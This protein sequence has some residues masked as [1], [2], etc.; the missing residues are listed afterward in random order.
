[1]LMISGSI[2]QSVKMATMNALIEEKKNKGFVEKQ[3][4]LSPEERMLEQFKEQ[5]AQEKEAEY[6]NGI[7]NKVMSGKTLSSEEIEYLQQKNPELLKKYR[8]MQEEKKSYERQLRRCKTKEEVERVRVNKINGYLAQAKSISHNA[9]IP[10]GEK[11]AMLEE[12]MA[13]LTNIEKVHAKFVKSEQY[14]KMPRE[15]EIAKE[16][17]ELSSE[18]SE[19]VTELLKEAGEEQEEIAKEIVEAGETA[20]ESPEADR[21]QDS[22]SPEAGRTQDSKSPEAGEI[23]ETLQAGTKQPEE[24]QALN[25]T[26]VQGTTS[27][28]EPAGAEG[29]DLA[30]KAVTLIQSALSNLNIYSYNSSGNTVSLE[31]DQDTGKRIDVKK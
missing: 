27:A 17:A 13:R 29:D 21:T 4:Q 7:A 6:T 26:H 19:A 24:V 5:A 22:K 11:K 16:R 20:G 28:K 3:R 30:K 14:R 1:M 9:V 8:E 23:T 12:I 18:R 2:H 10:K 25:F 15:Q 31:L